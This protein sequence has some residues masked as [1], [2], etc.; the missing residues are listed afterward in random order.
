MSI[1]GKRR[2]G[3]PSPLQTPQ[4]RAIYESPPNPLARDIEDLESLIRTLAD[5]LERAEEEK[6]MQNRPGSSDTSTSSEGTRSPDLLATP[7]TAFA[8]PISEMSQEVVTPPSRSRHQPDTRTR[9]SRSRGDGKAQHTGEKERSRVSAP[10]TTEDKHSRS[11]RRKGEKKPEKLSEKGSTKEVA[12]WTRTR[13]RREG[14]DGSSG[15]KMPHVKRTEIQSFIRIALLCELDAPLVIQLTTR[16]ST[17][18]DNDTL[19]RPRTLHDPNNPHSTLQ[20]PPTIPSSTYR[21]LH[22]PRTP[23]PRLLAPDLSII[24]PRAGLGEGMP[25][26]HCSCRGLGCCRREKDGQLLGPLLWSSVGC[27]AKSGGTGSRSHRGWNV[28]CSLV[29]CMSR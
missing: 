29:L 10:A 18:P 20:L 28:F 1:L 21:L 19:Y 14:L 15:E 11:D 9:S 16:P 24:T 3:V 2:L 26:C 13:S 27:T 23:R 8:S 4:S 25:W 6:A 22:L 5:E 17:R 12:Q 7:V